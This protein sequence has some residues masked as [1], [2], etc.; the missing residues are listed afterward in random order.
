MWLGS[1]Q[2]KDVE[3]LEEIFA[4]L[5]PNGWVIPDWLRELR[6][7]VEERNL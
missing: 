1:I 6:F 4:E 7:L 2:I 5:T 3:I